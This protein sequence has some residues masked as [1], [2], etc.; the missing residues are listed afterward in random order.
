MQDEH[1]IQGLPAVIAPEPAKR[2]AME[3]QFRQLA[4]GVKGEFAQSEGIG[5]RI[6]R[7]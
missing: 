2:T 6:H 1:R 3:A 7:E 5:M 4:A